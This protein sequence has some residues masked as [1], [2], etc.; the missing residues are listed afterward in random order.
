MA[1]TAPN[2]TGKAA[3]T[4]ALL[5]FITALAMVVC[6]Y[7]EWRDA[8]KM[9]IYTASTL[10]IVAAIAAGAHRSNFGRALFLGVA[11]AWIA[12]IVGPMNFIVGALFFLVGHLFYM[13]A[14][15]I[16]G[17][18][19]RHALIGLAIY[20]VVTT[21][22]MIYIMPKVPPTEQAIIGTYTVILGIMGGL[23]IG[24]LGRGATWLM[25]L[26]GVLFYVS[27]YFL[28]Q[29]VFLDGGFINS[30]LGYP[31]YYAAV[32]FF[33]ITPRYDYPKKEIAIS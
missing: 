31:L 1:Q 15:F 28:A 5:S 16:H 14:F 25:P 27:D 20:G 7:F 30:A 26:A 21:V 17:I 12:D 2:S 4:V 19:W 6:W 33:A 11:C 24:T 13:A 9:L 8:R 32:I 22:L 3:P 23:A 18:A 29:T 10:Y